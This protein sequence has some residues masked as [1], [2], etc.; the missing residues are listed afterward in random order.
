MSG[1]DFDAMIFQAQV[2]MEAICDEFEG[3]RMNGQE[4]LV[5]EEVNS[6]IEEVLAA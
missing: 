3:S 5:D 2:K 6:K 1:A 4:V